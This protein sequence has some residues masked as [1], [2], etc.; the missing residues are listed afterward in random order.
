MQK[1]DKQLW[2]IEIT[3]RQS[4][5]YKVAGAVQRAQEW[6]RLCTEKAHLLPPVDIEKD[7]LPPPPTFEDLIRDLVEEVV[8]DAMDSSR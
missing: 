7:K 4:T 6:C 3:V 5:T 2:L 8:S 1:S